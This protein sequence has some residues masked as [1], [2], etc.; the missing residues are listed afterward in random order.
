MRS[1]Q[2]GIID[3]HLVDDGAIESD[4]KTNVQ[5]LQFDL[6]NGDLTAQC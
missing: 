6:Q 4:E 3:G 5:A 1:L 2:I